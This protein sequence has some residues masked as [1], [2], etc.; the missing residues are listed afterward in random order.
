MKYREY[1]SDNIRT[2]VE[3]V[4]SIWKVF[5]ISDFLGK[6]FK[7]QIAEGRQVAG[8]ARCPKEWI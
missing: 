7:T 6:T 4:G 1:K 5:L 8:R 3:K 2:K